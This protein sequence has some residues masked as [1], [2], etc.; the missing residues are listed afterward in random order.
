MRTMRSA[1]IFLLALPGAAIATVCDG[2]HVHTRTLSY[3]DPLLFGQAW[4]VFPGFL[5]VFLFMG[6]A[7]QFIARRLPDGIPVRQS[8]SK[9]NPREVVE[10]AAAFAFVYLLSGYGNFDPVLLSVVFYC[11]FAVRW[12]FSYDRGWLFLLAVLMAFGG[13]AAEGAMSAAGLVT[14]RHV[15]LFYVPF[16]LGGLYLH[17]AFALREGMRY[18]AY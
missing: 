8:T 14:Y 2:I 17:G 3:P 12:L 11:A 6:H 4:W 1:R 13:M 7:Y 9:G 15:D 10:A 5:L 16:W 18:F